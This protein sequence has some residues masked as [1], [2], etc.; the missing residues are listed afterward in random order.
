MK[1]E[2][3]KRKICGEELVAFI[4]RYPIFLVA[5]GLFV[6]SVGSLNNKFITGVLFFTCL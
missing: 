2:I 3:H 4:C 6:Y 1:K 5:R